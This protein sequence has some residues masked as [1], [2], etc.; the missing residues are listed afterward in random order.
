MN[1][2]SFLSVL[3]IKQ[4]NFNTDKEIYMSKKSTVAALA[5]ALAGLAVAPLA[6][7]ADTP[8]PAG[9]EQKKPC[10]PKKEASNPCGPAKKK[11]ANPCGP[12]NPCGPKKRKSAD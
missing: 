3:T 4:S 5:I 8:A 1:R 10:A 9:A 6:Q 12:S 2:T 7:S 11:A